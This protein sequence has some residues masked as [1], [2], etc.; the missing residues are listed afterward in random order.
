MGILALALI[1]TPRFFP[2]ETNNEISQT[3]SDKVVTMPTQK[4]PSQGTVW[5]HIQKFLQVRSNNQQSRTQVTQ[6]KRL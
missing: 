5:E 1:M 4:R 2:S 6:A 3:V